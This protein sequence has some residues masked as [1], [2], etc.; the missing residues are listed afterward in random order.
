MSLRHQLRG[1][2]VRVVRA[3]NLIKEERKLKWIV[4][5]KALKLWKRMAYTLTDFVTMNKMCIAR[6][7]VLPILHVFLISH[8]DSS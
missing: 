4:A 8:S 7:R 3:E 5:R 1:S 6:V 2:T